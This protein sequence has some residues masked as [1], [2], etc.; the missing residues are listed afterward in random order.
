MSHPEATHSDQNP[1]SEPLTSNRDESDEMG[2]PT[3][4]ARELLAAITPGPWIQVGFGNIH[5]APAGEHPPVAKTWNRANGA[6]VAAAPQIVT[7]L[8]AEIDLLRDQLSRIRE[9]VFDEYL[10]SV[11]RWDDG[12]VI[13]GCIANVQ[14]IVTETDYLENQ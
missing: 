9:F 13:P 12:E 8:L 6:F 11:L 1:T 14:R 5:R 2:D 10:L 4:D 3:T 7:G